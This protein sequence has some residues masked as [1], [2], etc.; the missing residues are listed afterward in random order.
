M[1]LLALIPIALLSTS[2]TL[3]EMQKELKQY[4]DTHEFRPVRGESLEG[5][6][7]WKVY[8]VAIRPKEVEQISLK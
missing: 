4:R 2:C 8:G 7:D 5:H 1:K 6:A 3:T